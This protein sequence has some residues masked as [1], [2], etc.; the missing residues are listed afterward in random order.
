MQDHFISKRKDSLKYC[1][2]S[3]R[4]DQG[5]AKNKVDALPPYAPSAPLSQAYKSLLDQHNATAFCINTRNLLPARKSS[6]SHYN[7]IITK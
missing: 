5:A 7:E 2:T 4:Q 1:A 3:N 6:L